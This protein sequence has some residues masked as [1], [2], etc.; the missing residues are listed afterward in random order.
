MELKSVVPWGRAFAEYQAMFAL[1]ESDLERRILGCG[2]GSASFNAEL[3]LRGGQVVSVDPIYVFSADQLRQRLRQV[4]PNIIAQMARERGRYVWSNFRDPDHLGSVR[5]SAMNQFLGDFSLGLEQGRYVPASLP[6]LP[7]KDGQ[8]DLALCSHLLFAYSEQITAAQ[9]IAAILE[10]LRVAK[11]VRIYP[12]LDIEGYP[13]MHLSDVVSELAE[14][15]IQVD[16][17][18]VGYELQ[19]GATEMLSLSRRV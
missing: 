8:F 19:R 11:E 17:Q 10:M 14:A 1:K 2:D 16:R 18:T 5:M 6:E 4:Y 9:H 15:G 7:F 3:H 13:S 12:L